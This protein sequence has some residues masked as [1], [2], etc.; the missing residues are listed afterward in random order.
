LLQLTFSFLLAP[1][2]LGA[3]KGKGAFASH[4][5]SAFANARMAL[6]RLSGSSPLKAAKKASLRT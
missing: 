1:M 3:G 6:R 4:K 2:G 5:V